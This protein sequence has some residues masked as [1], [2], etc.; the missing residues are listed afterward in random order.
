MP[1]P[2]RPS[3]LRRFVDQLIHFFAVMLWVAGG[4]AFAAGL[5]ELGVAI[6]IVVVVNAV[7]AF[8]QQNRADR[9]ADR[10]RELLPMQ[11]TVRR[12][13]RRRQVDAADVVA[14]DVLVLD[15]GDR[16]PAD[17]EALAASGLLVDTSLLTGE[18][19]PAV[20]ESGGQVFAGTFVV[21]GEGE[22]VV[23]ATAGST[24]LA[25]IASLTTAATAPA[26]PLTGELRRVVRVISTIALAVGGGFFAVSLLLGNPSCGRFGVRD[27]SHRGAGARGAAADGDAVVVVGCRAD[28][29]T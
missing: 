18:S 27:R 22:A 13:G 29:Q 7:F 21:E 3:H 19:E 12:D 11:V 5:P 20:I 6:V 14:G 25:G 17:A 26:S 24:R 8:V 1:R 23:T 28:G 9:A 16:I 2:R 4:L 10:L 15:S